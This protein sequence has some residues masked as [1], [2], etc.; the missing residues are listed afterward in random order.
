[1]TSTS[2]SPMTTPVRVG[3]LTVSGAV[4]ATALLWT[5]AQVLGIELRVDPR[6]G[7]APGVISLPFTA[8]LTLAVCL[9]SW[10]AR[11]LL[12]RLTRRAPIIWTVLAVL[13]LLASFL[14]LLIVEAT[15]AAKAIL[16]LMH[17]AVAAVLIPVFSWRKS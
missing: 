6:N 11:A 7:R 15:G 2:G 1:M 13:V 3:A 17:V 16:A 10:G 9:L 4:L 14:P 12:D 8:T 5:T